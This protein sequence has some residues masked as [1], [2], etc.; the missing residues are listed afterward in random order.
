MWGFYSQLKIKGI[1][2][3]NS[4]HSQQV[5]NIIS[6]DFEDYYLEVS[7][8]TD[9]LLLA[10]IFEISRNTCL[11]HCKLDSTHFSATPG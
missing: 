3:Q 6:P 7:L 2:G 10:D 9:D 5:W 1:S 11:N 4:E 8:A